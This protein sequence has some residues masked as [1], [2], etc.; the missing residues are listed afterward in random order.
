MLPCLVGIF[1]LR[2]AGLLAVQSTKKDVGFVPFLDTNCNLVVKVLRKNT[3]FEE[4]EQSMNE[5]HQIHVDMSCALR[6]FEQTMT[7]R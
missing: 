2:L 5:K 7:Y 6:N 4:L 3:N 1:Y